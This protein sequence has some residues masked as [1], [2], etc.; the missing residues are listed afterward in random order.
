M[1]LWWFELESMWFVGVF[2]WKVGVFWCFQ[3]EIRW[4]FGVFMWKLGGFLVSLGGN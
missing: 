4:I 1:I 3:V 2:R